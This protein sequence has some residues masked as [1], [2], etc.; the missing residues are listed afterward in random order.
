MDGDRMARIRRQVRD[1]RTVRKGLAAARPP[2]GLAAAPASER[3]SQ[4]LDFAA[5]RAA[6]RA[7]SN[8]LSAAEEAPRVEAAVPEEAIEAAAPETAQISLPEASPP[9]TPPRVYDRPVVMSPRSASM[10]ALPSPEQRDAAPADRASPPSGRAAG[11]S[12][13]LRGPSSFSRSV[14]SSAIGVPNDGAFRQLRASVRRVKEA[15]DS[16]RLPWSPR[17][18]R[19]YENMQM[20]LQRVASHGDVTEEKGEE[21]HAWGD[22]TL[23][24]LASEEEMWGEA[25]GE[26]KREKE[27]QD[28]REEE[29]EEEE[30]SAVSRSITLEGLASVS[31]PSMLEIDGDVAALAPG[32]GYDDAEL[33]SVQ[34]VV[35]EMWTK[36]MDV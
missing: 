3:Q 18:L 9:A 27:E 23:E 15:R 2:T 22:M 24:S 28:E 17:H 31:V 11:D 30:E 36:A 21:E 26:A 6:V 7:R 19:S 33:A 1:R 10:P 29:E 8:G 4:A 14:S 32:D 13:R 5:L 16:E 25:D 12:G 35:D 34:R 20:C